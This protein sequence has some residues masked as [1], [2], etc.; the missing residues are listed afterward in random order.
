TYAII[1]QL[2][3][4]RIL[5]PGK[6]A[7]HEGT[8]L[9]NIHYGLQTRSATRST[10]I[11]WGLV[12]E[13]YA[14]FGF[15]GCL[16]LSVLLG[17]LYGAIAKWSVFTP[18]LSARALFAVILMSLAVQREMTAGVY[19]SVLFQAIVVLLALAFVF[20]KRHYTAAARR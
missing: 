14:N 4:P 7:S 9:L 11:G 10:T 13:A 8:Y 17:T 5:N 12:N 3:L 1:P 2:L 16:A 15:L 20:M 18:I 6:I 19:V